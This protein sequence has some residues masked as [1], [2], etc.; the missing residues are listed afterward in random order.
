MDLSRI[1]LILDA[2]SDNLANEEFLE[3]LIPKLGFNDEIL[4][5][6]PSIVTSNKGGLKIWQ[7]PNQFSKYMNRVLRTHPIKSYLEIG[8]RWGGTFVLT[9]EYLKKVHGCDIRSVAV[10]II[11]S[12][13]STYCEQSNTT[14]LKMNSTSPEFS[15]YISDK[16]FDMIFIDGDHSYY[17]VSTDFANT[18][19]HA[20][21]FVFHDIDNAMCPGVGQ[22]WNELKN[23]HADTYN[24][25][26]FTEQYEEVVKRTGN[27]YLG[28]GV[29]IK[30]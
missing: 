19:D 16:H 18:K 27:H 15:Q 23:D 6:Q 7:Y 11:P 25:L 21:I 30:K 22:F 3:A 24:F 9:T 8:C 12:P 26:E 13:V 20:N 2:S 5:E 1:G 14:F 10:D 28:I 29:A 17:G 4:D